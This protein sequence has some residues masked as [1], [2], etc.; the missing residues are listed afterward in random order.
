MKNKLPLTVQFIINCFLVAVFINA[1]VSTAHIIKD[2]GFT[3]FESVQIFLFTLSTSALFFA[4]IFLLLY[5]L[6]LLA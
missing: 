4:A 5:W 2:K 3:F 1:V 6:G